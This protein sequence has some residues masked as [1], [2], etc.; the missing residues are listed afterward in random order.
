MKKTIFTAVL[1]GSMLVCAGSVFAAGNG[2]GSGDC[3]QLRDGSCQITL[4]G[5]GDRDQLR[6]GSCQTA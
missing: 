1:I 5:S 3:D 6:D 2:K 4:K